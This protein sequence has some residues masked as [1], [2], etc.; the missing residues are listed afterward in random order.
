MNDTSTYWVK[1]GWDADADCWYVADSNV[2]GLATGA[3]T[4]PLLLD[5]L[6]VMIPELLELNGAECRDEVPIELIAHRSEHLR[7]RA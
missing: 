7:M 4:V 6:R 2:P 1:A 5:K 3:E